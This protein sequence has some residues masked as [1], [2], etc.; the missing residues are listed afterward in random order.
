MRELLSG[1]RCGV[2]RLSFMALL[3]VAG[4]GALGSTEFA[5]RLIGA[6]GQEFV[7]EE[8]EQIA[9]DNSLSNDEKRERFRELGIEDE[10][11]IDALLTL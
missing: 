2:G 11:L 10:D 8:L 4:C 5:N 6:D 1:I 7:L 3:A 9:N